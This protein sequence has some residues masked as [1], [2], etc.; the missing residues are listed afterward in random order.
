MNQILVVDDQK[1]VCYSLKRFLESEKYS[2]QTAVS[3][4]EALFIIKNSEPDLVLMDVKMPEMNGLEVLGKI[5]DSCPRVQ[6]IM[7]M[8]LTY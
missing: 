1:A 6:V 5:K 4:K 7:T 2:V 8:P 3:G